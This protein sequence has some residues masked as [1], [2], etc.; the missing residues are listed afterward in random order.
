MFGG[1]GIKGDWMGLSQKSAENQEEFKYFMNLPHLRDTGKGNEK[2]PGQ[3]TCQESM[4]KISVCIP[5]ISV[6]GPAAVLPALSCL[7]L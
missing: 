2:T 6:R 4:E 3:E 5:A 1:K 7:S